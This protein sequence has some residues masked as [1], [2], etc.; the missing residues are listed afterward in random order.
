M[1]QNCLV[2]SS[3]NKNKVK[4]L[5]LLFP[6]LGG[7]GVGFVIKNLLYNPPPSPSKEGTLKTYPSRIRFRNLI[8]ILFILIFIA[9]QKIMHDEDAKLA[10]INSVQEMNIAL[11]GLYSRFTLFMNDW[12]NTNSDD[13]N[14][15]YPDLKKQNGGDGLARGINN[16]DSWNLAYKIVIHANNI[17]C[18]FENKN[19]FN[20]E[21]K[22]G[23][24]EAYLIRAYTYFSL[25]RNYG[26]VP[27]VI[28]ININYTLPKSTIK[29][30]YSLIEKDLFKASALLPINKS[31]SRI[32]NETPCRGT[33]KAM[34]AEVYL[35]MGGYPL[36]DGSKYLEAAQIAR[37]VIDSAAY[38]G[39][40]LM[41]DYANLWNGYHNVNDETMFGLYFTQKNINFIAN[42]D[43]SYNYNTNS[44]LNNVSPSIV[45]GDFYNNDV[46]FNLMPGW[47][48]FNHFPSSY[49]KSKTFQTFIP[50]L[51]Y[52]KFSFKNKTDTEKFSFKEINKMDSIHFNSQQNIF[53]KKF[54]YFFNVE[55]TAVKMI[56]PS[57]FVG[58][59]INGYHLVE[60][61]NL[62]NLENYR[63]FTLE[64]PI[65][66]YRYAHTLL[67]Y[68]EAKA[69]SGQPDASAY[70]AVNM[71]RRRA[72]K[73]NINSPSKFDL[74]HGLS[75]KQFSDS[76]V[77]ERAWE[78]CAEPEGRWYDLVRTESVEQLP[79]LWGGGPAM[80]KSNYFAKIPE[81]EIVLDPNLK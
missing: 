43:G 19:S 6:L 26:E 62:G 64:Q 61:S 15:Y 7:A 75:V 32:S 27:L 44:E 47:K 17:I 24:G 29:D 33:A 21:L 67:T 36:N 55:D 52:T 57:H 1:K 40:S 48:F 59:S 46:P 60:D 63:H 35:T 71:V 54:G 41:P 51:T 8:L 20:K 30:I 16:H 70:E 42:T 50:E 31:N 28:D 53:Y 39:F 69:R 23:L 13:C 79:I 49:R 12:S 65:Y 66:I 38:F 68:A 80:T 78:F 74:T 11:D 3:L 37:E 22:V 10:H 45:I 4:K 2:Y 58:D 76:V 9:C 81:S 56:I 25:V 18:Q 72:N 14:A 34:L 5:N 73:V 77:W